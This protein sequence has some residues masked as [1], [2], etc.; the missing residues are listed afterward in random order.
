MLRLAGSILGR[1][2]SG[3][4]KGG[5]RGADEMTGMGQRELCDLGIG[6]SEVPYTLGGG[7]RDCDQPGDIFR[8]TGKT[9]MPGA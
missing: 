7:G 8:S 2:A 1:L 3:R 6:T 9:P 5:N 4:R